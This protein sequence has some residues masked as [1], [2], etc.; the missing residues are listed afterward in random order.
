[1][2]EL[3]WIWHDGATTRVHLRGSR[4]DDKGRP[5]PPCRTRAFVFGYAEGTGYAS[6]KGTG[7]KWCPECIRTARA[8]GHK[9]EVEE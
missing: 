8:I 4:V 6:S 1:M 5:I 7:R 2:P 9:L 3:R